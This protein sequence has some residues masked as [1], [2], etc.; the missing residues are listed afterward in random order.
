MKKIVIS[1]KDNSY[2]VLIGKGIIKKLSKELNKRKLPSSLF[3]IIDKNVKH[4]YSDLLIELGVKTKSTFVLTANE[5]NKTYETLQ[6]IHKRMI[7]AKLVRNSLVI[8]IGGGITGDVG[9]FAASTYMRGIKYVQIPTTLLAA[10]DSSVGGKTGI[11]FNNT[12]NIIGSFHQP[13]LVMIDTNFFNTLP[14]EE[15]ICGTGELTKYAFTTSK[16]FSNYF[17]KNLSQ[18]ISLNT[19]VISK[20][21][22]ES[23]KYKGDVVANDE[24]ETGL[25][26][27]LNFGHTFA[28]AIEV[29]QNHKIKHGQAVVAGIACAL[30]L[31]NK[32]G[33][34]EYE[35][36]HS[37]LNIVKPLKR[38]VNVSN[39]NRNKLFSVM[40]RD[41]KN[42]DGEIKFVLIK[43]VG[44][45][46]IDYQVSKK[47]V[48]HS[49][50]KGLSYF[51]K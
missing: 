5:K 17:I 7:E 49:I 12:K 6:R 34:L 46:V 50:D 42:D 38:Y 43:D 9:G 27:V 2:D 26:K 14:K 15:I 25:R 32:V 13:A 21:I 3:V 20:V 41:K 18:I 11:N 44:E 39:Y 37:F 51:V 33:L 4:K 28:H 22:Y 10:V 23:I 30:H 8:A 24:K 31:S 19:T 16:V 47:D 48:L 35:Q 1:T 40:E 36:L 45:T 29:E